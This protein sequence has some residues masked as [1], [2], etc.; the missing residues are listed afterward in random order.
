[1]AS[2]V[3]IDDSAFQRRVVCKV[4]KNEGHTLVEAE[5]G[6][7][8]LYRIETVWPDC[9]LVDLVMPKI[10]GFGLLAAMQEN[11]IDIPVIVITADVQ[12]TTRQQC[13]SLGARA[14]INKPINEAEVLE[15]IRNVLAEAS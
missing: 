2:F 12:D 5:N 6:L 7:Q 9:V 8:G 14:F 4:V 1:M 3:V 10:D 15:T 11:K 13:Q